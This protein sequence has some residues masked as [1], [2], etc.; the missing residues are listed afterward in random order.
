MRYGVGHMA[1]TG[2]SSNAQWRARAGAGL[3]K[4]GGV[5]S[6][7][8]RGRGWFRPAA[9]RWL[10]LPVA[11]GL[12]AVGVIA[13]GGPPIGF[14]LV[15]LVPMLP[16][17]IIDVRT[18]Q[19]PDPLV[20]SM[21]PA[22]VIGW[23]QGAPGATQFL[24]GAALMGGPVLVVHLI[25]PASMGFGDVKA[26]VVIGMLIGLV[27]PIAALFALA[28]ATGATAA[29]GLARRVRCAPLGPGL[30]AGALVALVWAY[31]FESGGQ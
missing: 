14:A 30:L 26:A 25:S 16:A 13:L 31:H 15:G 27:Q 6:T 12:L 11:V 2:G 1:A 5:V 24:A 18:G 7:R 20:V 28:V 10:M 8:P 19:L 21:L 3:N 9:V 4:T 29:W 17:A 22:F 23:T